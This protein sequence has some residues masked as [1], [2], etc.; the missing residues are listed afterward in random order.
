MGRHTLLILFAF[1]FIGCSSEKD[2]VIDNLKPEKEGN[3][4]FAI[5]ADEN[6]TETDYYRKVTDVAVSLGDS[7]SNRSVFIKNEEDADEYKYDDIFNIKNY[8]LIIVF[9]SN[10]IV[11]KTHST[12]ELEQF[13]SD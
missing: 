5:F 10:G 6:P 4:S 13:F 1:L 8:P 3:Y 11:L 9:D 7:V 12:S 2:K